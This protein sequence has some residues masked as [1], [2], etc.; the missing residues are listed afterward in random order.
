MDSEIK[1]K[2]RF[3]MKKAI[4]KDGFRHPN[5]TSDHLYSYPKIKSFEKSKS[6]CFSNHPILLSETHN[7]FHVQYLSHLV[8]I[9]NTS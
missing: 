8:Q 1:R 9:Q 3:R 7:C 4:K 6:I 5:K 2:Y